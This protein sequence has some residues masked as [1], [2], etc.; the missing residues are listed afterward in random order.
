MLVFAAFGL[1]SG[2]GLSF[3]LVR[4]L[5]MV[6]W[7]LAGLVV[8]ALLRPAPAPVSAEVTEG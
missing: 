5:R 3:T 4:R 6:A 2:L 8:L 7:S 1:G